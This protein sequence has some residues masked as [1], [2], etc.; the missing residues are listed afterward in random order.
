MLPACRE[1]VRSCAQA[2]RTVHRREFDGAREHLRDAAKLLGEP[3]DATA[4]HPDLRAGGFLHHAQKE[5]VEA[6][7][8]LA[9]VAH[10]PAPGAGALG[11]E[12]AAYLN[13]LAE[14][15]SELRRQVLDCLHRG[16]IVEA[17]LLVGLMNEVYGLLVTVDYSDALTGDLRRST[18]ALRAAIE[19]TRSDVTNVLARLHTPIEDTTTFG[20]ISRGSSARGLW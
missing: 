20:A 9:Y 12:A 1:A 2:I 18:D 7:L 8:T 6:N 19:R 10:E 4:A 5:Y 15:A 14:A 13:G 11:V 3:A 16:D 17:E